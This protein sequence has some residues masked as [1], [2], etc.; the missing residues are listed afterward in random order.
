VPAY[1]CTIGAHRGSS[2]QHL[3]NTLAALKAAEA[4]P[5][6]AFVEFDVSTPKTGRLSFFTICA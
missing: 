3:E 1:R 5:G 4:D 2:V 6:F